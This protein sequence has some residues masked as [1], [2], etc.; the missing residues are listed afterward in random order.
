MLR[1]TRKS[2]GVDNKVLRQSPRAEAFIRTNP[3]STHDEFIAQL[4]NDVVVLNIWPDTQQ[5]K[6]Y[7]M[8]VEEAATAIH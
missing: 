1:S 3:G 7:I 6:L 8:I 2:C 5:T 4:D